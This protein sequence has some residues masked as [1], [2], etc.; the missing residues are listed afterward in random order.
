MITIRKKNM[1]NHYPAL[2]R[3]AIENYLAKGEIILPFPGLPKEMLGKRAG[4]FVS[5]HLKKD[6][7]LRGCIGT[8]LPTRENIAQEIIANAISSAT[9]DPRFRPVLQRE[10]PDLEISVDILSIPKVIKRDWRPGQMV[11]KILD[12]K[13]YG[14]IV[15]T[16][17]GRRGLLLPD[18]P[19]VNSVEKQISICR[20]K[21]G[22]SRSE[23]VDLAIFEVERHEEKMG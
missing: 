4:A 23:I 22:I 3:R 19:G 7:S 1:S 18:I 21:A 5:L 12:P 14:L 20:Q 17:D 9:S 10:L 13:K 6:G 15:S 16:S 8:F 11:P 2:A